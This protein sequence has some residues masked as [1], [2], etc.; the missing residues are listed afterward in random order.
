MRLTAIGAI[1]F[2]LSG[3]LYGSCPEWLAPPSDV[4][5]VY[6]GKETKLS[7]EE[8][9]NLGVVAS[10]GQDIKIF[11]LDTPLAH[12]NDGIYRVQFVDKGTGKVV[13]SV[14]IKNFGNHHGHLV[15][16][17][18]QKMEELENNLSKVPAPAKG[19][20][21]VATFTKG[22]KPNII[23][24]EDVRGRTLRGLLQA[25]K[26]SQDQKAH[27]VILY[28]ERME[29]YLSSMKGK[30]VTRKWTYSDIIQG[31]EDLYVYLAPEGKSLTAGDESGFFFLNPNQVIVD[32]SSLEMTIIDP[33]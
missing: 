13:R 21:K 7:A 20:F 24:V 4:L 6:E 18:I 12:R 19:R 15:D 10:D 9:A 22:S 23:E 2:I 5:A 25:S 28:K 14:V 33:F 16:I 31:Q 1:L 32:L 17:E 29:H 8:I 26:L 30:L 11:L 27:L 3:S